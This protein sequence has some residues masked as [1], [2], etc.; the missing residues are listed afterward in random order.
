MQGL[1]I[2]ILNHA[3][4]RKVTDIHFM[5]K[6]Q[7]QVL[8][9]LNGSLK[10]Y[11]TFDNEKGSKLINYIRYI[12]HIDIN[13][14]LKPQTGNYNYVTQDKEY[15]LRVSSLPGI[16]VDSLVVR[17]L[18]NHLPLNLDNLSFLKET[19]KFLKN[20]L[21][22]NHGLFVVSGPTGSGKSTTLYTLLDAINQQ[23]GRNIVSLE[24]PIEIKK[25]YCL[26]IQLNEMIGITYH[27]SLK[28]ILR[29]D[30]DVIMIGEIRDQ[31]TANLAITS[32][33]TGH[34]VLTTVHAS[35]TVSTIKRLI[36]LGVMQI[37]L[38]ELLIG[39]ISQRMLFHHDK[40]VLLSEH[41]TKQQILEY[42]NNQTFTYTN[43]KNNLSLLMKQGYLDKE[44]IKWQL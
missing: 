36:N 29:H 13:Y 33:L 34:L 10:E 1:L 42:F 35:D 17:I 40:P 14:H 7:C 37:D 39:I 23:G 41:L 19:K 28:Q 26:Q 8:F 30:P 21:N 38:E 16:G 6:D 9:R 12:S 4:E 25:D 20:I 44:E 15:Y 11:E 31:L 32:A 5:L 27:D 43:F 24:D 22:Y 18:N 2:R 3:I